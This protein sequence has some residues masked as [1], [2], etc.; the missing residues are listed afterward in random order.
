MYLEI[1][2]KQV[3]IMYFGA[4][5]KDLECRFREDDEKHTKITKTTNRC[6]ILSILVPFERVLLVIVNRYTF[7]DQCIIFMK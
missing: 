7:W 1:L 6:R 2:K 3:K 4:K 5:T